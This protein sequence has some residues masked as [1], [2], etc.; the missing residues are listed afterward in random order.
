MSA[1]GFRLRQ[2]P[3][4]DFEPESPEVLDQ[5]IR[6]HLAGLGYSPRDLAKL[7]SVH[8]RELKDLYGVGFPTLRIPGL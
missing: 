5:L 7:L 2:P 4:L 6:L 3:Q 8:E 1:R